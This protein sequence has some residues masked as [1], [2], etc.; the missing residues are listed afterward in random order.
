MVCRDCIVLAH[1]K[2]D[3]HELQELNEVKA[4]YVLTLEQLRIKVEQGIRQRQEHLSCLRT[5]LDTMDIV[6]EV[7]KLVSV[8]STLV[9]GVRLAWVSTLIVES[10]LMFTIIRYQDWADNSR[11]YHSYQSSSKILSPLCHIWLQ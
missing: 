6:S 11:F 7:S 5:E 4:E 10:L 9:R 1:S 8:Y 3:G 2:S